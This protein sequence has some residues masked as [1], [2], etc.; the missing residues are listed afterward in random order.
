MERITLYQVL[1]VVFA[2]DEVRS[3][4][5]WL[6]EELVME[7][8]HTYLVEAASGTGKSSFC[9]YIYGQRNDYQ[10]VIRFDDQ[11]IK[12]FSATQWDELRR[13]SLSILFQDLRLFPELT[14]IE[15]I[16]LKNGL[17]HPK[18][19]RLR[20][21]GGYRDVDWINNSL[22]QLDIFAKKETLAGK[23]SYGQQQRVALIRA[24]CQPFDFV[25]LDEPVSHLDEE[26]SRRLAGFALQEISA[27]GA[28]M[29]VTSI[30]KHPDIKYDKILSL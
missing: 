18:G 15:N 10:G 5:V 23:L 22:E 24:F 6:S 12:D 3:S 26:N 19:D 9:S 2:K 13:N 30:G 16:Q 21:S 7:K 28:G 1:P 17:F 11:N 25:F 27:L 14:V 20:R 29:V 4:D 8:G